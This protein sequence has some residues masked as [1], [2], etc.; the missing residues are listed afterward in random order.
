MGEVSNCIPN[1]LLPYIDQ[2]ALDKLPKLAVLGGD[3]PIHDGT[4]VRDYIHEVDLAEGH[5][6]ALEVLQ[7]R[8]GNHVWNLGTGQGYS[9]LE[10]LNA[11]WAGKPSALWIK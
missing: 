7:T 10:M 11:S 3:Y 9:V 4:G 2:V 8:T 1:N 5:L 6:R